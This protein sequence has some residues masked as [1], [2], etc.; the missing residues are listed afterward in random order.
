[1]AT[2]SARIVWA[3][4]TVVSSNLMLDIGPAPLNC[5]RMVMRPSAPSAPIRRMALSP[6]RTT[7][8]SAGVMPCRT[9]EFAFDAALVADDVGAVAACIDVGV[10]P[11]RSDQRIV[12]GAA[13]QDVSGVEADDGVVA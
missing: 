11:A 6:L 8:S 7:V 13:L 12:A 5:P 4:Q 1:M 2:A 3:V 9:S 10:V